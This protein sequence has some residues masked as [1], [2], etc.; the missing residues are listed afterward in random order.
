[1]RRID[2]LHLEHPF[3]G[4]RR[5]AKQLE[6]EGFNVGRVRV[7]MLMRRRRL[8]CSVLTNGTTPLSLRAQRRAYPG[9][10]PATVD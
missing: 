4:A 7:A 3:Y 2:E 5:L 10:F 9:H 1:M 8:R 6:R